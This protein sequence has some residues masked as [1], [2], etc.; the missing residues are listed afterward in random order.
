MMIDYIITIFWWLIKGGVADFE[1]KLMS[2]LHIVVSLMLE[3]KPLQSFV[4]YNIS[5]AIL[6]NIITWSYGTYKQTLFLGE[7]IY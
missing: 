3:K 1:V 2:M 7:N 4:K 6:Q 5:S